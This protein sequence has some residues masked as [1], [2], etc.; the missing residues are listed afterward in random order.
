VK[1]F[2]LSLLLAC[3]CAGEAGAADYASSA[4]MPSFDVERMPFGSGT[5]AAGVTAGT[6]A[7]EH[8]A[9]GLYHVPNYL[10]GHPTAATIWPREVPVECKADAWGQ[11]ICTGY[12]VLP[13]LGRGE[14][15]FVRPVVKP[16]PEPPRPAPPVPP[17]PP[18][19]P[20]THKKPLE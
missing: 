8:V 16:Q 12:E 3:A 7:A 9:D 17:P 19:P 11:P 13:A 14:Y 2:M 1:T 15:I 20:I 18:P 5:P 4:F 10:P 6:E